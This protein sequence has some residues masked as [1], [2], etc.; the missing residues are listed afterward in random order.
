MMMVM[1]MMMMMMMMAM[2][3]MMQVT[4]YVFE[5]PP[6]VHIQ[7]ALIL[8]SMLSK[9]LP[10]RIKTNTDLRGKWDVF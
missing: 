7:E 3:T 10:L 8:R 1:K 4:M 5:G 9:Q 6:M 2:V